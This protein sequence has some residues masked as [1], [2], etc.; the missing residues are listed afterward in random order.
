MPYNSDF[1]AH[2]R[3]VSQCLPMFEARAHFDLQSFGLEVQARGRYFNFVPQFVDVSGPQI[4][5]SPKISPQATGFLGWLPYFNK[6]WELATDKIAFKRFC[7][8]N[9]IRAPRLFDDPRQIDTPVIVKRR[10]ASFG[11][12]LRGPFLPAQAGERPP[13]EKEFYEEFIPGDIAKV[14]YWNDTLVCVETKP[15]PRTTGDG[16]RTLRQL[17][18][19]D[20]K[21][22]VLF[23][24]AWDIQDALARYQG[25]SLDGVLEEGKSV[26]TDYRY[27]SPLNPISLF[28]TNVLKELDGTEVREALAAAGPVFWRGIPDSIRGGT[29]FA[30][31]AIIDPEKR[32]WF[33]EMNCNPVVPPDAYGAIFKELFGQAVDRPPVQQAP[34]PYVLRGLLPPGVSPGPPAFVPLGSALPLRHS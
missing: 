23:H 26:L 22:P 13:G 32:I 21:A 10:S 2:M 11:E 28:N 25:I 9:G 17:V 16:R 31:D 12:G 5:Y 29:L 4:R 30:A 3:A 27:H 33:L 20:C 6:R 18:M 34:G 8:E 14:W 15:M 7:L 19:A 1:L 24:N